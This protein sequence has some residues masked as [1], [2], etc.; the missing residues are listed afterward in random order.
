MPKNNKNK[1]TLNSSE[2]LKDN[3]F[4]GTLKREVSKQFSKKKKVPADSQNRDN[5]LK[6]P[7]FLTNNSI[8]TSNENNLEGNFTTNT[9]QNMN[10]S[11]DPDYISIGSTLS[12]NDIDSSSNEG[13]DV[14]IT[15]TRPLPTIPLTDEAIFN[16]INLSNFGNGI[17]QTITNPYV[18]DDSQD[19]LA[20]KV[21]ITL[22]LHFAPD[23]NDDEILKKLFKD[24]KNFLENP[25]QNIPIQNNSSDLL[26]SH[27]FHGFFNSKDFIKTTDEN[28]SE[29]NSVENKIVPE[30]PYM[31]MRA[32]V[33]KDKDLEHTHKNQS[34]PTLKI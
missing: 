5:K 1:A 19:E 16:H 22:V 29:S 24:F 12:L 20:Y 34:E 17:I 21:F 23:K 9:V 26:Q 25:Y 14:N 2:D 7:Y 13:T 8:K 6:D 27:S 28:Q 4:F 32:P 3:G 30:N 18:L 10:D 31:V 33:Q 11:S 15:T